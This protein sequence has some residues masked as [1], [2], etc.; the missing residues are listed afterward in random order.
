M[1][2]VKQGKAISRMPSQEKLARF[3]LPG[4]WGWRLGDSRIVAYD[5][6]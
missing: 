1:A 3:V 5:V 6:G 4:R 2:C